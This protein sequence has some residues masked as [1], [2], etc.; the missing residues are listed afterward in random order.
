MGLDNL[1]GESSLEK[2][3]L[4]LLIAI[5]CLQVVIWVCLV[6]FPLSTLESQQ[7]LSLSRPCVGDHTT[8]NPWMRLPVICRRRYLEADFLF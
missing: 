6:R 1:L 7:V 4:P 2:T 5:N 3:G 8:W